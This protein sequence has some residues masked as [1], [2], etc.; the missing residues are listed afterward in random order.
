MKTLLAAPEL[1]RLEKISLRAGTITFVAHTV[2]PES[3]CPGCQMKTT[4]VHSRYVRQVADLPWAGLPSRLELHTRKFFC[5]NQDCPRRIFCERLPALVAS[6]GRQTTR[7]NN[8]LTWL[9]L[10]LG[11]ESG[12]R[13]A[14]QLGPVASPD[15]L[16]NRVRKTSAHP[17]ELP[18]TKVLGVD[19]FAF[20]RGR[21]YGT[22]LVDLE[23]RAPANVRRAPSLQIIGATFA[24]VS[25]PM[26]W[27]ALY[28]LLV[29]SATGRAERPARSKGY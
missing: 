14:H 23:R 28:L 8:L 11:E 7:L 19:D 17:P 12:A 29:P 13:M 5:R 25:G 4:K 2:R 15:M 24:M 10:A 26:F 16:L 20:R 3:Y 18:P 27:P 9:G 22:I 1:L 6:S 21:S